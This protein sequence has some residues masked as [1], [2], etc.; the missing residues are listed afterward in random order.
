MTNCDYLRCLINYFTSASE[1]W[2]YFRVASHD[3]GEGAVDGFSTN[4][5][6]LRRGFWY[7]KKYTTNFHF[8][9][10]ICES[11]LST[12][13]IHMQDVKHF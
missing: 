3:S 12:F 7:V 9:F 13:L 10:S 6:Y 1:L 2:K 4:N 8:L 5:C 11:L